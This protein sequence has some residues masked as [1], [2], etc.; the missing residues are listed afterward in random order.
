MSGPF[1]GK[2]AMI[3]GAASGIG[4]SAAIR[5]A[6]LGARVALLDIES[7][8]PVGAELVGTGHLSVQ[9]DLVDPT[10]TREAAAQVLDEGGNI[11]F[12]LNVAA[13]L[14]HPDHVLG[15]D[16]VHWSRVIAI[17]LIAPAVLVDVV[18]S[19]MKGAGVAGRIVNVSSSSAF[20]AAGDPPAAY[21]CSK[22]AIGALTRVAA[23]ELGAFGINVNAVAPGATWTPL[24]ARGGSR[25]RLEKIVSE[26]PLAN[27]L[28]RVSTADDVV[29]AIMYLC[30]PG[31]RQITGQT[32]HT[33]AGLVV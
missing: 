13:L 2:L 7:L 1:S 8:D 11:D 16:A 27:L 4:R 26:G 20:R 30:E 12:L 5:F 19:A 21:A 22:A 10:A 25:E 6:E 28:G 31:S 23:A 15:M 14:K 17:N 3:T 18:G 9:V 33:S 29:S 32:I 24:A